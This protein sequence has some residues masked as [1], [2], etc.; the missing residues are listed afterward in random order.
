[1][2]Q[3]SKYVFNKYR[4]P[5]SFPVAEENWFYSC[6]MANIPDPSPTRLKWNNK[7]RTGFWYADAEVVY[8]TI[9]QVGK[10]LPGTTGRRSAWE[11]WCADHLPKH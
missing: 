1:M 3:E 9:S 10:G 7:D 8:C 5:V 11:R 4:L 6:S 2:A